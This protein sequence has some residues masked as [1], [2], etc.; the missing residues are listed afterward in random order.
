MAR[1]DGGGRRDAVITAPGGREEWDWVDVNNLKMLPELG[2]VV[3]KP[4]PTN[5]FIGDEVVVLK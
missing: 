3:L 5:A 1:L 2:A 4:F